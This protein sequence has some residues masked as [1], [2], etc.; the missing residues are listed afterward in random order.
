MKSFTY[1][2]K[3]ELGIHARPAGLV[4]REAK[5]FPETQ[6]T[7]IKNGKEVNCQKLMRVMSLGVRHGEAVLVR[8]EG[9]NEDEA[10][11]AMEAFFK[12]NL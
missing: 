2:I 3:D 8:A 10:I 11:A 9:A 1:V 7:M 4:V 6:I 12:A 5:K